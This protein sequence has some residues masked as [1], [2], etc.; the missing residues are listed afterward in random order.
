MNDTVQH[1]L[2]IEDDPFVQKA[3][4]VYLEGEG[5]RV[6]TVD[7]GADMHAVMEKDPADLAIMD[8]KLPK[9]D[10]FELTRQLRDKYSLGIIIL[11]SKDDTV[12]RV[13][14]L[15]VGADD[16]V[17]KPWEEREL[18]PRIRSVM[19]R[20]K[21]RADVST[22]AMMGEQRVVV[23]SEWRLNLDSR[24]LRNPA[25]EKVELTSG[26]F[27]LL[28]EFIEKAGRVLSRD[29][30]LSAI[31]N[32]EWEPFDRSI[33]VLVTRLRRKVEVDS[34]HPEIIKTVRGTGYMFASALSFE[35]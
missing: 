23:S 5:Y 13:V 22:T 9:D 19:R 27:N 12:D 25:G 2:V 3:V 8:L 7:N 30:L 6:S 24:E 34:R 31:Y 21:D 32:R 26:E 18:L 10:G 11:T 1:I 20:V 33:D 28:H 14:G 35:N 4:R 17:T 29:H 15:E 16:Y